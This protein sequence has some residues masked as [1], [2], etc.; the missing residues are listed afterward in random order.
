MK[1]G[2][3][4]YKPAFYIAV[5]AFAASVVFGWWRD[6]DWLSSGSHAPSAPGASAAP[7]VT[8]DAAGEL[9]ARE[10]ELRAT[11]AKLEAC[12]KA[13]WSAVRDV[14]HNDAQ[15]RSLARDAGAVTAEASDFERQQR[16]LCQVTEDLFRAQI[17]A[18]QDFVQQALAPV[19][20]AGWVDDWLQQKLKSEGEM[21]DLTAEDR[22]AL[23]DGY[24]ALW[25]GD[26]AKLQGLLAQP[27]VDYPA[28]MSTVRTMWQGEDA[29]VAKVVGGDGLNRYRA[30]ELTN[31]TLMMAALAA[32]AGLPWD[33]GVAW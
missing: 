24:R 27:V 30:S 8:A 20:T 6:R 9:A 11:R 15:A 17:Q 23:D 26:G 16:T 12:E 29:L 18:N 5:V 4:P 19:G 14:I 7:A 1:V 10:A 21:F 13:R 28:V 22:A 3:N 31:R 32:V 33:H 25:N 2:M